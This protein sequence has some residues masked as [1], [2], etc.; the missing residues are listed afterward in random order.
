MRHTIAAILSATAALAAFPAQSADRPV[1]IT[2]EAW[3]AQDIPVESSQGVVMSVTVKHGPDTVKLMRNQ[4]N[5]AMVNP[6]FALTS[7]P[8]PPFCIQPA[9][10]APGVETIGELELIG[11]LKRQ[12]DGDARVIVVD[13]RTPEW[14]A[15]G[16]I[17]GSVNLPWTRLNPASGA[18]PFDVAE[19]ME[20]LLGVTEQEGLLDFRQAKTVVLFCNG[21]WCGQSP[22]SIG[23]LLRFGYPAHKLKWYRGGM[24]DW[25]ILGL[26]TVKP[27]P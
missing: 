12:S 1:G 14:V 5:T 26:T 20:S 22:N 19:I 18:T 17:P 10:L 25:L 9:T 21:M 16:T 27:V 24:Q 23:N 13:S 7:R 2:R 4:D 15:R 11:Y 3:L 6:D 8:C